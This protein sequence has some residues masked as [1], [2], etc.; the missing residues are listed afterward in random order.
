MQPPPESKTVRVTTLT[1]HLRATGIALRIIEFGN[2]KKQTETRIKPLG[3][4]RGMQTTKTAS[5]RTKTVCTP[6]K[7]LVSGEEVVLRLLRLMPLLDPRLL[8]RLLLLRLLLLRGGLSLR[9]QFLI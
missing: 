7:R 1:K 8:L 4:N 9:L 6:P 5:P 2:C 3:L